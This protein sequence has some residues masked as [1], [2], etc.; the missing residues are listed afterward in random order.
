MTLEQQRKRAAR[1]RRKN[2]YH[3]QEY[4][5]WYRNGEPKWWM[6]AAFLKA[7]GNPADWPTFRTIEQIIIS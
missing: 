3:V 2:R 4:Q 1:W 6:K 5:W 7:G